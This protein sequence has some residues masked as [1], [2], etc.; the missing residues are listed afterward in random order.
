LQLEQ[1]T[2]TKSRSTSDKKQNF[3]TQSER[4]SLVQVKFKQSKKLE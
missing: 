3:S 1:F 4:V 2:G